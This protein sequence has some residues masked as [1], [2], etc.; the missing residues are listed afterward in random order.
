MKWGKKMTRE[1]YEPHASTAP[2]M[3]LLFQQYCRLQVPLNQFNGSEIGDHQS[4]TSTVDLHRSDTL[5]GLNLVGYVAAAARSGLRTEGAEEGGI[6][7]GGFSPRD[8]GWRHL[9]S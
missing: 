7:A 6:S 2:L 3:L 8:E 9:C 5:A 4:E 1:L